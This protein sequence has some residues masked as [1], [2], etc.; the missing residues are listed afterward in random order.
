REHKEKVKE[1][2][3]ETS[4]HPTCRKSGSEHKRDERA[5]EARET[6]KVRPRKDNH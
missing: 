2:K 6:T 4:V 1:I 3:Q 5:E